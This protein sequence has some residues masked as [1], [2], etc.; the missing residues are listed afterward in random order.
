[1]SSA[2]INILDNKLLVPK[3]IEYIDFKKAKIIDLLVVELFQ[4]SSFF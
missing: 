4:I 3:V 1:M 2:L